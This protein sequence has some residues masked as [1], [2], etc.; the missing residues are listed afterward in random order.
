ML[1]GLPV[2]EAIKTSEFTTNGQRQHVSSNPRMVTVIPI[3][4]MSDGTG[5]EVELVLSG[6]CMVSTS[7]CMDKRRP[8]G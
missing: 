6:G 4:L 7:F 5:R 8:G 3:P 2:L 1:D